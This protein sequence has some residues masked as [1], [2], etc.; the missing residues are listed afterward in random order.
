MGF[1]VTT[2]QVAST[3][4]PTRPASASS[5]RAPRPQG[6]SSREHPNSVAD[7]AQGEDTTGLN[8]RTRATSRLDDSEELAH[9]DENDGRLRTSYSQLV[10]L[11]EIV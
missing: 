3:H 7:P 8:Q 2:I 10:L 6:R 5:G 11:F 1:L 4:H 9:G